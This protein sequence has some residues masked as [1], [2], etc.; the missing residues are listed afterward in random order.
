[1]NTHTTTEELLDALFSMNLCSIKYSI[2]SERK[3]DVRA[4]HGFH[5]YE[6][7]KNTVMSPT[8]L[9]T[10]NDCAGECQQQFSLPESR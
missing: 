10:K 8:G 7:E 5:S 2:C 9:G 3:A 1:M 6:T 4:F